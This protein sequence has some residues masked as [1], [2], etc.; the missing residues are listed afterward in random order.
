LVSVGPLRGVTKVPASDQW[1]EQ[2]PGTGARCD[3]RLVQN[4][5]C[6]VQ[7]FH[8]NLG[9]CYASRVTRPTASTPWASRSTSARRTVTGTMS[10]RQQLRRL[11]R[12]LR[13][14]GLPKPLR[15]LDRIQRRGRP[16]RSGALPEAGLRRPSSHL[17]EPRRR[18]LQHAGRQRHWPSET[19]PSAPRWIGPSRGPAPTSTDSVIADRRG[20]DSCRPG[21]ERSCARG[22]YVA[23]PTRTRSPL[24]TWSGRTSRCGWACAAS[25]A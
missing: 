7:R 3:R 22:C 24:A 6:L 14:R 9:D 16:R 18:R 15:P 20:G 19:S 1:L 2:M 21:R 23:A 10:W 8:L 25:R 12:V 17:L 5:A 11:G 13:E 4:V